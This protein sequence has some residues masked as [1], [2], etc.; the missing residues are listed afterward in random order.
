[1]PSFWEI[2]RVESSGDLL[3]DMNTYVSLPNEPGRRP[4]VIVI[5]EVFG[6][7]KHIQA[8]ADRVAAAGYFAVA[9]ALFHRE[10]TTEEIRGTNPVYAYGQDA[11]DLETRQRAV[12]NFRDE[13]II[14][15]I[16]TTMD[17]L[18]SHPRVLGDRIG[19]V[20]FCA[21]GRITYLAAAACPGLAAAVN[22]YGG[23]TMRQ[24]GGGPTPFDRTSR[25]QCPVMGNFGELDQNPTAEDVK[26]IEAEFRKYSKTCDFKI[27]P[28]AGHGFLCDERDSYHE[29]SARDAWDRTLSWFQ[30]HLA[31]VAATA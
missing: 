30:R 16:N 8:V 14:L 12:A 5:Q 2:Q 6:V 22:F 25:I 13:N 29:P 17:W 7:N 20:G 21:G 3:D 31:P 4:A 18:R 11:P 19:I 26:K 15:D 28:G 23:N 9:P 27:Y 1:M 24:W 10:G